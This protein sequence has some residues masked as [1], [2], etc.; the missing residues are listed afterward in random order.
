MLVFMPPAWAFELDSL[1]P[2]GIPG[3]GNFPDMT[4]T[5]RLKCCDQTQGIE[6][7]GVTIS[8]SISAGLGYDSAP[9]GA[10]GGSAAFNFAPSI[11][12][13]DK[14][15]G[16]GAFAGLQANS[17]PQNSVQGGSNYTIGIGEKAVLPQNTF[18]FAAALLRSQ[19]TGFALEPAPTPAATSLTGTAL[20][21]SDDFAR[22]MIIIT[23]ELSYIRATSNTAAGQSATETAAGARLQI[24]PDGV[25]HIIAYVHATHLAYSA[26]GQNGWDY[27]GLAGIADDEEGLWNFRLLGGF[28]ARV[29]ATGAAVTLPVI[30]AAADWLPDDLT[31][32]EF[33]AAHEI[34]DPDR[35][36]TASYTITEAK[37]RITHEYL[38]NIILTAGASVTHAA[39]FATPLIETIT[40]TDAAIAWRL[41]SFLKLSADYEFNDRQ[42]NHLRAANEHVATLSLAW[43]L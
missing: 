12:I 33:S 29:P 28:T 2:S 20:R 6:F 36:D 21:A 5:S 35:I 7:A 11:L 41:N 32:L 26:A 19:Q 4:V 13:A 24:I 38:R 40:Q 15:I 34:D 17:Y 37:L 23:P 31:S 1:L 10:A 43:S 16:L 30:E 27:T 18:N 25:L 14:T 8:P 3:F 39:F 42:A 9:N 22:G